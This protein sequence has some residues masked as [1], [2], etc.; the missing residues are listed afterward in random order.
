[1]GNSRH[2]I[3]KHASKILKF[4][5]SRFLAGMERLDNVSIAIDP[6]ISIGCFSQDTGEMSGRSALAEAMSGAGRVTI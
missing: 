6:G 4:R 3:R 1:M 5:A 2:P